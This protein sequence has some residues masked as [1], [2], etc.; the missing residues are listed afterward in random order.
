MPADTPEMRLVM[1]APVDSILASASPWPHVRALQPE[2]IPWLAAASWE[3]YEGRR[4]FETWDATVATTQAMLTGR[5]G[6]FMPVASPVAFTA[7]GAVAGAVATVHR[8]AV[9]DAPNCP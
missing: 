8:L 9:D 2:D 4:D 5:W 6:P 3:A 1:T 7:E